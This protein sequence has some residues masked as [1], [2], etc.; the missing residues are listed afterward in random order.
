MMARGIHYPQLD[1]SP[2]QSVNCG[3]SSTRSAITWATR[4]LIR[5]TVAQTRRR[6]G[7]KP[8]SVRTTS[9]ADWERAIE[10]YD[11]PAELGGKY[12]LLAGRRLEGGSWDEVR[13]HL[14]AGK[15]VL[16]AVHY[17]V[18]RRLAPR[19]T[20]SRTFSGYHAIPFRGLRDEDTVSYDPLLDGRYRGC[21]KGPVPIAISKVR[22]AA[23]AVGK[24]EAGRAVVY[25]Y[26]PERA[27]KVGGGVVIP[28]PDEPLTLGGVLADITELA[29][30]LI[31]EPGDRA[32]AIAA[33]LA[34]LLGPAA[35]SDAEPGDGVTP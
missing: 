6:M 17:G 33:D 12:E 22:Q 23:E 20:G 3:V 21:P 2:T 15:L 19:R 13:A 27:V 26:L 28:E 5:P 25:G 10:S 18:L 11:T 7:F 4:G 14:A 35:D 1:G 24:Q 30:D 8:T 29:D 34:T 32:R 31:G 9:P 16:L